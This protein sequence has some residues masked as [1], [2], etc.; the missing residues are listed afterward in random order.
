MVQPTRWGWF[1]LIAVCVTLSMIAPPSLYAAHGVTFSVI[2]EQKIAGDHGLSRL[3]QEP[4]PSP[5]SALFNRYAI[6]LLLVF[7]S[8]MLAL[9]GAAAIVARMRRIAGG[10]DEK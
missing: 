4:E 1:V 9:L 7:C 3:S 8:S 2:S 5:I 6:W 10:D